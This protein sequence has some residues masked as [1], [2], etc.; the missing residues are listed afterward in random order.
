MWVLKG[1]EDRKGKSVWLHLAGQLCVPLRIKGEPRG[2]HEAGESRVPV[3][4][5]CTDRHSRLPSA[6]MDLPLCPPSPHFPFPIPIP[7]P[8]GGSLPCDSATA[9]PLVPPSSWLLQLP[10]KHAHLLACQTQLEIPEQPSRA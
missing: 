1:R 2:V 8:H 3:L 9:T 7:T 4:G 6:H 10:L 5:T